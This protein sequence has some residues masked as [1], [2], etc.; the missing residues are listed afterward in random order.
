M[1]D[2]GKPRFFIFIL[3]SNESPQKP[4]NPQHQQNPRQMREFT[5]R[6]APAQ[7]AI[8][9]RED[10][11]ETAKVNLVVAYDTHRNSR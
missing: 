1:I 4:V 7:P 8:I 9:D 5:W 2:R 10:K 6:S 3:I 11:T